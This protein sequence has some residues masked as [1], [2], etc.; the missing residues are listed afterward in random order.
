MGEQD[1]SGRAPS[2]PLFGV[3]GEVEQCKSNSP[4]RLRKK[5]G[6]GV[7]GESGSHLRRSTRIS[8]R[9]SQASTYPCNRA[10]LFVA[11]IS[12][13]DIRNCNSR[14]VARSNIVESPKLWAIGKK[15][16]L[17]CREDEQEVI[18]DYDGM[19]LRDSEMASG[20]KKGNENSVL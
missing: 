12:D 6:P 4:Q 5:K 8:E 18:K 16:G 11:S 1:G 10:G 13:R 17:G 2:E 15:I 20:H 14:M 7:V 19:E 3:E 9:R